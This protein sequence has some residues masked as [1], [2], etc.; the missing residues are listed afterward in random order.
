MKTLQEEITGYY[1]DVNTD[2]YWARIYKAVS[3]DKLLAA[4][5]K[6]LSTCHDEECPRVCN[7]IR[8]AIVPFKS[9]FLKSKVIGQLEKLAAGKSVRKAHSAVFTLGQVSS[10]KSVRKLSAIL[11]SGRHTDPDLIRELKTVIG[12]LMR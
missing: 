8:D 11:K 3:N 2:E 1:S 12:F 9:K 10:K 4:M 6:A 7:F 5:S